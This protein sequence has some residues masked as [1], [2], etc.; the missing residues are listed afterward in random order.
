[1]S[2][3]FA[4]LKTAIQDYTDNNETVFVSQINNFIKAAEETGMK[5][6]EQSLSKASRVHRSKFLATRHSSRQLWEP[7]FLYWGT[8]QIRFVFKYYVLLLISIS[9]AL[10][11][12]SIR[13]D[14]N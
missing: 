3:T 12:F 10:A 14:S 11:L 4:T 2:F 1:M 7:I 5:T 8:S 9:L 13:C 6:K